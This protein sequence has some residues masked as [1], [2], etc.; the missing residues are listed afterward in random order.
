MEHTIVPGSFAAGCSN[1]SL[2][3]SSCCVHPIL[4]AQIQVVQFSAFRHSTFPPDILD[5]FL[6]YLW[7]PLNILHQSLSTI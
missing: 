6:I 1:A 4:Q 2:D 3:C 7:P 5:R